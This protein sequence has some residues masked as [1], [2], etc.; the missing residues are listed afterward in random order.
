MP[1]S[2]PA[3]LSID[4]TLNKVALPPQGAPGG[5]VM[6]ALRNTICAAGNAKEHAQRAM[7]QSRARQSSQL[8]LAGGEGWAWCIVAA[9]VE[10]M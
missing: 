4:A 5:G 2:R 1:S 8:Y 3:S 6:V 7:N 9:A 10:R